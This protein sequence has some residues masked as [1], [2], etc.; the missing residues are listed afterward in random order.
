MTTYICTCC[1]LKKKSID[2]KTFNNDIITCNNC[3][4]YLWDDSPNNLRTELDFYLLKL[5]TNKVYIE[6]GAND[7]LSQSNTYHLEQRGWRGILV[8]PCTEIYNL[9]KKNRSKSNIFYNNFLTKDLTRDISYL[10]TDTQCPLMY[11]FSKEKTEHPVMNIT[12]NKILENFSDRIDFLSLDVEGY[13]LNTLKGM[14]LTKYRPSLICI[15]ISTDK[16]SILE[17]FEKFNFT[18]LKIIGHDYIFC[19]NESIEKFI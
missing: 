18:L 1:N 19:S 15:E 17:I 11:S 8:E 5:G 16:K 14:D 7:G 12:I 13:E 9:C 2:K 4:K 6:A 10:D 3:N